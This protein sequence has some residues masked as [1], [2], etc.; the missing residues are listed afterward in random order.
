MV[1]SVIDLKRSDW[2]VGDAPP[3][4]LPAPQ[5]QAP[6]KRGRGRP[7]KPKPELIELVRI[8]EIKVGDRFRK[9]LGDLDQLA[10]NIDARGLLLS[11]GRRTASGAACRASVIAAPYSAECPA[12]RGMTKLPALGP[13]HDHQGAVA[14]NAFRGGVPRGQPA[15]SSPAEGGNNPCRRAIISSTA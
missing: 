7:P 12:R 3:P 15:T 5:P 11:V 6:V 9:V 14:R 1:A 13:A 10:V 2:S 8:A 4:A